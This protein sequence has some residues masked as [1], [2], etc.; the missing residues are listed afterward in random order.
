MMNLSALLVRNKCLASK[1]FSLLF[2][3][4]GLLFHQKKMLNQKPSSCLGIFG[5][6]GDEESKE[7]RLAEEFCIRG[8][9][10]LSVNGY[11][12]CGMASLQSGTQNIVVTKYAL[13]NRYG[14]DCLQKLAQSIKGKHRGTL[15]IAHT[16]WATHGAKID[17]N[18]HPHH[19]H[20]HRIALVHNGI[21]E[22]Y[23]LLKESLIKNGINPETE[24]DSE[25]IALLIG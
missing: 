2:G 11:D 5:V 13:E 18:A 3:G 7:E 4:V 25:V 22:N 9:R 6:V 16:R 1:Q 15:G 12:S 14:G 8:L 20:R 24:T 10:E 21:I 23:K 17:Q 19:D